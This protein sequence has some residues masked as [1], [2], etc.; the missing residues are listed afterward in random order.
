MPEN[1]GR[2]ISGHCGIRAHD[3]C[4]GSYA[5]ADCVCPCHRTCTACGQALP[6]GARR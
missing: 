4:R 6:D 1:P 5:G 2:Y 3:R